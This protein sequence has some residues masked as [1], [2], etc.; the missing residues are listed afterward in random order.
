MKRF[1]LWFFLI[2][3]ILSMA[4]GLVTQIRKNLDLPAIFE[5]RQ[6][7]GSELRVWVP[8][9]LERFGHR[10]LTQA[11]SYIRQS[12]PGEDAGQAEFIAQYG[13]APVLVSSIGGV[14][15]FLDFISEEAANEYALS[16][17]LKIVEHEGGMALALRMD[18]EALP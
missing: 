9:I 4:L 17:R 14:C 16:A 15:V 10:P 12:R 5:S 11:I 7:P 1:V 2:A 18:Q 3:A 6:E 13:L 8:R